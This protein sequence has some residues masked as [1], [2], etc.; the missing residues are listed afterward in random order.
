MKKIKNI[1]IFLMLFS[2]LAISLKA[3]ENKPLT[4]KKDIVEHTT[5]V[6][7]GL[8][9]VPILFP[10]I[11][12]GH[13][14]QYNKNGFD[15]ALKVLPLYWINQVKGTLTYNYYPNPN[16]ESQLFFGAGIG[17]GGLIEKDSISHFARKFKDSILISP[18]FVIGKQYKNEAGGKRFIQADL[19][20]PVYAIGSHNYGCYYP[21]IVLRYGIG[22]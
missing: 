22:F 14:M 21:L 16:P 4:E 18:E 17:V 10:N 6:D 19:S 20:F 12:I 5:Y 2:F 7:L 8:G 3:E 15:L 9:P 1:I 13:R 11:G